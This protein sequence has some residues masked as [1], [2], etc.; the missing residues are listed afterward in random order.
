MVSD[1]TNSTSNYA[2]DGGGGDGRDGVMRS[3]STTVAPLETNFSDDDGAQFANDGTGTRIMRG[4][5]NASATF[6]QIRRWRKVGFSLSLLLA[7]VVIFAFAAGRK[8]VMDS[9][10]YQE[11]EEEMSMSEQAAWRLVGETLVQHESASAMATKEFSKSKMFA[12]AVI[13]A[14]FL[15]SFSPRLGLM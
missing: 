11:G 1:P 12:P 9:E 4:G 15:K 14:R 8:S 2:D 13:Y 10:V 7:V 5:D 6:A 3:T